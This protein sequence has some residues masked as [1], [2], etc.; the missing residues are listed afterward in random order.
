MLLASKIAAALVLPLNLSILLGLAALVLARRRHA[1]AAAA[2]GLL[3]LAILYAASVPAVRD[4]LVSPLERDFPPADPAAAPAA[5][6]VVVLGGSL[7]TGIPPRR[8]PEL[9]DASDRILHASRLFRAGRAP[10]VVPTGGRLPWSPAARSEAA[11]MADLL[12]EW[13]VPREAILEEGRGRTTAENASETAKLL[14]GRGV[15]RVLLVTSS[16][17]MRRA[18]AAFRVEGLEVVPSPCDALVAGPSAT[19][20]LAWLPSP[21]ALAGTHRALREHLGLAFYRL[22]GRA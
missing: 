6:A 9:A 13:G 8:G 15:R 18:L 3:A 19:G 22:T 4:A 17:H 14:R 5:G 10:L 7:A 1:G 2:V 21:E 20:A 11:E 12:V 16:I